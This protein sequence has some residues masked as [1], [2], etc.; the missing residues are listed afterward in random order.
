MVSVAFLLYYF[1]YDDQTW[2]LD[3]SRED[4]G[5]YEAPS[6]EFYT[7]PLRCH[8]LQ[9]IMIITQLSCPKENHQKVTWTGE[10]KFIEN[11]IGY[12]FFAILYSLFVYLY[13]N[14]LLR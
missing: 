11:M 12:D 9:L 4:S 6:F 1:I 14:V 8:F 13:Y 2:C 5:I 10:M 3:T 7:F